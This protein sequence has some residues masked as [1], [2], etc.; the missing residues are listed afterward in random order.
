MRIDKFGNSFFMI[1]IDKNDLTY[2][3]GRSNIIEYLVM[4]AAAKQGIDL[5][6]KHITVTP[7]YFAEGLLLAVRTA[8][9]LIYAVS[10]SSCEKLVFMLKKLKEIGAVKNGRLYIYGSEEFSVLL[11]LGGDVDNAL[12]VMDSCGKVRRDGKPAG[13][14]A[15]LIIDDI[16]VL[17][18]L[19]R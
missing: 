3:S 8:A 19:M 6:N 1:I 12:S 2:V 4:L 7:F 10:V 18:Y 5:K 17:L 14:S 15:H 16:A 11:D 9:A 13:E